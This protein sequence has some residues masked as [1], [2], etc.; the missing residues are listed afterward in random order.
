MNSVCK[1]VIYEKYIVNEFSLTGAMQGAENFISKNSN[2]IGLG[3]PAVGAGLSMAISAKDAIQ[4]KMMEH[5]WK[6]KGCDQ[7]INPQLKQ[8]CE[9]RQRNMLIASIG[10]EKGRCRGA[11]DPQ[12]CMAQI[13]Q[14]ISTLR[15]QN[16]QEYS[17]E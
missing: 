4:R 2:V 8:Q 15:G 12:A 6:R 5:K 3:M 10:K 16:A 14:R 11:K 1:K 7:E 13:D 17:G 9:V